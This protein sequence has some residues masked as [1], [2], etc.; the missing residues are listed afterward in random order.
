MVNAYTLA[1][2]ASDAAL[3][4]LPEALA[5]WE[6]LERP[7]TDRCQE[8]S[9]NFADTRGM[10]QGNQFVGENNETTLYDP[11]NPRRHEVASAR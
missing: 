11:T 6:R 5:E 7:Y 3:T 4:E 10:S 1:Q 8:R 2:A 9:Q